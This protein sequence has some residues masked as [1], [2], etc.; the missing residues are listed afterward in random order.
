[1]YDKGKKANETEMA[2]QY[3]Y[4]WAHFLFQLNYIHKQLDCLI[5]IYNLKIKQAN[6]SL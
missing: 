4:T 2:P 1:M 6:R 3:S 5:Q